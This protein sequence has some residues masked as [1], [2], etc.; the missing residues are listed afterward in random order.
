[1]SSIALR[2]LTAHD[3]GV[4]D[5]LFNAAYRRSTGLGETARRY[6]A[7]QPDG[8]LLATLRGEPAGMVYAV[9]YG[10]FAYVGVMSVHPRAQRRGVGRA[11]MARL[12]EQLE[13]KGVRTVRLDATEAG[14][15]LYRQFGFVEE[16]RAHRYVREA[17]FMRGDHAPTPFPPSVRN[18]L[19]ADLD[20]V[21]AFDTPR[22]GAERERVLRA[23]HRVH[24]ERAFVLGTEDV[25]GYLIAQPR[26]LGPWVA[27]NQK[28]AERLL[29]VAL[30]LPFEGSLSAIAPGA[31][32]EA[33]TLLGHYGFGKTRTTLH[34]RWGPPTPAERPQ[35]YGQVSF[36][37]G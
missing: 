14:A 11:L 37:V 22:F 24:P 18:M 13:V 26:S 35:V 17:G 7:W 10:R 30:T 8:W 12:L 2:T 19:E 15:G 25:E 31:N 16:D 9:Q 29:Q 23:L 20:A 4:A 21:V 5:A 34:M 36:A 27:A 3:L 28:A 1:V 32:T 33:A 6:L